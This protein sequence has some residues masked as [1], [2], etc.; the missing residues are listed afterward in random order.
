MQLVTAG[1]ILSPLNLNKNRQ[2]RTNSGTKLW[3][4]GCIKESGLQNHHHVATAQPPVGMCI[5][6]IWPTLAHIA[7]TQDICAYFSACFS[8]IKVRHGE[9]ITN[10]EALTDD[11]GVT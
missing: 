9:H 8:M 10:C 3:C 1:M 6:N 5:Y 2:I 7:K 4:K 11:L